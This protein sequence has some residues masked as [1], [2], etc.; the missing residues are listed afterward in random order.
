MT[1]LQQILSRK[2]WPF[3]TRRV[4]ASRLETGFGRWLIFAAILA[5]QAVLLAV[6]F[7]SDGLWVGL[8]PF[9]IDHPYHQYQVD[10]G[11]Q[12]LKHWHMNGYD[13]MFGGGSLGG[14]AV[15]ASAR[16]PVLLSALVPDTVSTQALYSAYLLA[17]GLVSPLAIAA[18]GPVLRMPL[19]S[20][21]ALSLAGLSFWWI[22][23]F[24]WYHTA[25]MAAYVTA[26]F[27][28]VSF[29][30]VAFNSMAL[31]QTRRAQGK[32]ILAGIAGG[33]GLWLH[34]LF[35]VVAM[36][37]VATLVISHWRGLSLASLSLRVLGVALIATVLNLPWLLAMR[38]TQE[39]LL[40]Q[41]YQKTV[42]LGYLG[43]SLMGRWDGAM[44][45]LVNPLSVAALGLGFCLGPRRDRRHV[46]ALALAG[47]GFAALAAFGALSPAIGMMQPNRFMPL[48]FML[49]GLAAALLW[50]DLGARAMFNRPLR[51]V[52]GVALLLL[53]A[54]LG[55]EVAREALPGPH[56]H[57][58]SSP[59]LTAPPDD[60]QWLVET[61]NA[62]TTS[63]ARVIFENSLG[64]VYGGGHA[65]GYLA[66]KTGREFVGGAYPFQL[67]IKSFW[68]GVALGKPIERVSDAQLSEVIG[69]FNVGWVI[70]HT[71]A[72]AEQ[73]RRLPGATEVDQRKGLRIF[74][75]DR[76]HSY[77]AAGDGAV[78][79]RAA[80]RVTVIS[81][82]SSPVVL[83]YQWMPGLT[84]GPGRTVEPIALSPNYPAFVKVSGPAG[85]FDLRMAR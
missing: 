16:L 28:G 62:K 70:T 34:P 55:R 45:S 54:V 5:V 52:G 76:Q 38:D 78:L 40:D 19:A 8:G 77:L 60:M 75:M 24:H 18:I 13:P 66:L 83:R 15:N 6:A 41:P 43:K 12:L 23:A 31:R 22:G 17:C 4:K 65:A 21:L 27:T 72:L 47:A 44:G 7:P 46:A 9:H 30:L 3:V 56:G 29:A 48:A 64:R 1:Q 63:G 68:D 51:W 79:A 25:G 26:A 36:V 39:A 37:T 42:G 71:T 2:V 32:V 67:P 33:L 85:E 58:G 20:C 50:A 74:S 73:V 57:Y 10:F 61:V 81:R 35:A 69:L 14:M 53:L 84:A 80:D 59:E 82:S 49:L 11:R